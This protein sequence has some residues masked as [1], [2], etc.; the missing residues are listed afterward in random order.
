MVPLF[1]LCLGYILQNVE[2][3]KVALWAVSQETLMRC[4]EM[5][6]LDIIGPCNASTTEDEAAVWRVVTSG[7]VMSAGV[8]HKMTPCSDDT[9]T[10]IYAPL[11]GDPVTFGSVCGSKIGYVNITDWEW[12]TPILGIRHKDF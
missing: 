3:Y 10:R 5:L 7:Q 12:R 6:A 2:T 1:L 8:S 9:T 4:S 11:S